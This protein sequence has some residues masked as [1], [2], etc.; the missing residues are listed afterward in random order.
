MPGHEPPFVVALVELDEGVRMLGNLVGVDPASV[1]IGQPVEVEFTKVDD[2]L[3]L[4]NWR[5]R[6]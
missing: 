6:P 5:P 1:R 2:Q 3:S 4:P